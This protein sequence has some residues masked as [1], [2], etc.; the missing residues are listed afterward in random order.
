MYMRK[1]REARTAGANMIE[2]DFVLDGQP[3]L[4]HT[5]SS[6]EPAYAI[7]VSRATRPDRT[8]LAEVALQKELPRIKLPLA[9]DEH[10]ILDLRAAFVRSYDQGGFAGKIDYSRYPP[11]QLSAATRQWIDDLLK[12]KQLR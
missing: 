9:G 12:K 4:E 3:I 2:L 7:I 8:D 11:G 10:A 1:R 6:P 5:R